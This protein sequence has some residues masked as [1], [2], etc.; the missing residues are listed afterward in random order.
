[1]KTLALPSDAVFVLVAR[2]QERGPQID[3]NV[4]EEW[5]AGASKDYRKAVFV[6]TI[7]ALGRTGGQVIPEEFTGQAL[8][9]PEL[10]PSLDEVLADQVTALLDLVRAGG[11]LRT[12]KLD[13]RLFIDRLQDTLDAR[14]KQAGGAQ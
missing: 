3:I 13:D 9:P 7:E 5:W 12:A 2:A 8:N 10:P 4:S 6:A 11:D 14:A 1:M